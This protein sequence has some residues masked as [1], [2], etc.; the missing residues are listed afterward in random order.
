MISKGFAVVVA[1]TT[2]SIAV[3]ALPAVADDAAPD[4]EKGRY[5]LNKV[6]EGFV[7]LDTQTGAVSLCSQRTLGWAC[8]AAPEDRAVLE[9]EI[10]RLRG[11]NAALKKDILARGLPLPPGAMPEAPATH[12]NDV[13]LRLPN[14]ADLDRAAAFVG[15]VWGKF[16]DAINNAQKQ[17]LHG[18]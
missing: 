8:L 4:T 6:A 10:A 17:V 18:G 1:V 5:T 13:T 11:E 14:D 15:R 2:W 12:D 3:A 7:R 16:V 9:N